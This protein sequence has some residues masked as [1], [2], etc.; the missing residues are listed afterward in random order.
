MNKLKTAVLLL[1]AFVSAVPFLTG[2]QS[3]TVG[4]SASV[5]YVENENINRF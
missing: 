1:T 4:S 5:S 2:C 3:D